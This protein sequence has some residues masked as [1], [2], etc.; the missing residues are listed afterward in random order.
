MRKLNTA[1]KPA[2]KPVTTKP[3]APATPAKPV[4]IAAPVTTDAPAKPSANIT[5]TAACV[6]RNRTNFGNLS[7]RDTAYLG[8]YASFAKRNG[9]KPVTIADIVASGREPAYAG[10]RKPHDAGVINRLRKAGL[11]AP[12]TDGHSFTFTKLAETHAAYSSAR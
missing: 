12:A 1:S 5:R 4:A 10:S 9:G 7:D 2:S 3:V 6:A 11:I 8:F